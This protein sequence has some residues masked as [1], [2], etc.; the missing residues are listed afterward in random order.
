MLGV[1]GV[2]FFF[3]QIICFYG[4]YFYLRTFLVF[5]NKPWTTFFFLLL[6]F[7]TYIVGVLRNGVYILCIMHFF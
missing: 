7:Y 1:S 6:F 2:G 4:D 5:F 3:M